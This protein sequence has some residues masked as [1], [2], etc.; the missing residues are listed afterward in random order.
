[1]NKKLFTLL[2]GVAIITSASLQSCADEFDPQV[3]TAQDQR[4]QEFAANFVKEFGTPDPNHTWGFGMTPELADAILAGHTSGNAKTRAAGD[5][6]GAINTNVNQ[7]TENSQNALK[8]VVHVPGWPNDD[9]RYY[10]KTGTYN[11]NGTYDRYNTESEAMGKGNV[12]G[13]VTEY[14]IQWVSRWVRNTGASITD[15]STQ[16]HVSEFFIQQVSTDYDYDSDGQIHKYGG[17]HN[18]TQYQMD[19]LDFET[20]SGNWTHINNFNAYMNLAPEVSEHIGKNSDRNIMYVMSSGT[21]SM[22]YYSS[23]STDHT[24]NKYVLVKLKWTEPKNPDWSLVT[25]D[26]YTLDQV[27]DDPTLLGETIEREGYY[28]CFDYKCIKE[29]EGVDY[30]GDNIYSNWILK[31]TPGRF[32]PMN[33]WPKRLMCEDLGNTYDFDFN[34]AVFDLIFQT[35]TENPSNY[36]CVVTL[37]AAGGTMPIWVAVNPAMGGS[38]NAEIHHLL[39]GNPSTTPV[40][41]INGGKTAEPATYRVKNLITDAEQTTVWIEVHDYLKDENGNYIPDGEGGYKLDPDKFHYEPDP[42]HA[43]NPTN[44]LL[45]TMAA[46]AFKLSIYI[47]MPSGLVHVSGYDIYRSLRNGTPTDYTD[48]Y[49]NGNKGANNAPQL[50]NCSTDAHWTYEGGHIKNAYNHFVDWVHNEQ[51]EYRLRWDRDEYYERAQAQNGGVS[52]QIRTNNNPFYGSW[53][54][55]PAKNSSFNYTDFITGSNLWKWN[56]SIYNADNAGEYKAGSNN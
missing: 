48:G 46:A 55:G 9:G 40:N 54:Y 14:E 21:E 17:S 11:T 31:L 37:Q 23:N 45:A 7:W 19:K 56:S 15:Y 18:Y 36:D 43:Y 16:L 30:K 6:E 24:F 4:L 44:N 50:F 35:N 34:D 53:D 32:K 29:G 33:R 47:Q 51:C 25:N 12:Q 20:L 52:V 49:N 3:V 13:D 5:A 8:R 22:R 42:N 28:I 26:T 38:Y 10:V 27:L 41:V 1:M 2:S 39:G